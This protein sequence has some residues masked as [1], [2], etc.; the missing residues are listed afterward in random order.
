MYL[1]LF[2]ALS[3]SFSL[4]LSLSFQLQL[5]LYLYLF[6]RPHSIYFNYRPSNNSSAWPSNQPLNQIDSK[7]AKT[8]SKPV[9]LVWQDTSLCVCVVY[10]RAKNQFP[11]SLFLQCLFPSIFLTRDCIYQIQIALPFGRPS[12]KGALKQSLLGFCKTKVCRRK[13]CNVCPN[14]ISCA[15]K[16]FVSQVPNRF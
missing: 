15:T 12:S 6:L 16:R 9:V 10:L 14:S 8:Q 11:L 2:A 1:W 4:Y 7:E 5:H 13:V 3:L